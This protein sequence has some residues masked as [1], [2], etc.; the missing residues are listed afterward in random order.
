VHGLRVGSV[1]QRI[2]RAMQ[3]MH[4]WALPAQ[5][6]PIELPRVPGG[7]VSRHYRT[8]NVRNVHCGVHDQHPRVGRCRQL[9]GLC[10]RSVQQ[11]IDGGVRGVSGRLRHGYADR[12]QRQQVHGV[13]GGSVQQRV[14]RGVH[15][16]SCRLRH[17]Y[18]GSYECHR[19]HSVC[20]RSVQQRINRGVHNM[21]CRLRHG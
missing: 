2:G 3:G 8:D 15:S 17:R 6:W 9:H 4:C 11:R 21:S 1:Q 16:M 13:R 7:A 18:A 14:D 10:R 20:G 5:Q 19:L 12:D